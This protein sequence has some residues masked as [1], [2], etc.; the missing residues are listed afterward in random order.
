M[1]LKVFF[2]KGKGIEFVD[3]LIYILNFFLVLCGFPVNVELCEKINRISCN[4]EHL[5]DS[6]N[7][8]CPE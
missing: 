3:F 4:E 2:L 1:L 6:C 5:K 8:K 7:Q